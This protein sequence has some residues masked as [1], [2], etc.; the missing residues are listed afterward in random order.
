MPQ[1][2]R[3]SLA[4]SEIAKRLRQLGRINDTKNLFKNPRI[5]PSLTGLCQ[6]LEEDK[7]DILRQKYN[8][9]QQ[10]DRHKTTEPSN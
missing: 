10:W 9:I 3:E 8:V 1:A 6:I 4:L 5:A 7:E 2:D